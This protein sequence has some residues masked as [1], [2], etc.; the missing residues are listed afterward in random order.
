[1]EKKLILEEIKRISEIMN[2]NVKPILLEQGGEIV[3]FL[4]GGAKVGV[5]GMD[6]FLN[7]LSTKV[8][9]QGGIYV[10]K[11]FGD[12]LTKSVLS[13]SE[14]EFASNVIRNVFA[15]E[16]TLVVNEFFTNSS[17]PKKNRVKVFN[18]LKNGQNTIESRTQLLIDLGYTE[19]DKLTAQVFFD[20]LNKKVATIEVSEK[21]ASELINGLTEQATN[22]FNTII[23]DIQ[24]LKPK[25]LGTNIVID[26]AKINEAAQSIVDGSITKSDDYLSF[27]LELQKL[28]IDLDAKIKEI[29]NI[30]DKQNAQSFNKVSGYLTKFNR[31]CN[32]VVDFV[33]TNKVLMGIFKIMKTILYILVGIIITISL[34][35]L[36]FRW[37][38]GKT[39]E[40]LC[41]GIIGTVLKAGDYCKGTSEKPEKPEEPVKEPEEPVKE[42]EPPKPNN[43]DEGAL[44]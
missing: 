1:M 8:G 43:D 5:R 18:F 22:L 3:K 44:N 42:P 28:G 29:A 24:S 19:A 20:E 39:V 38:Y 31:I 23:N 6:D 7:K 40:F 4:E 16:I 35:V 41:S 13:Q 30:K 34:I 17:I 14:R 33:K 21:A 2:I 37:I 12:L 32:L 36:A 11:T 25:G 27:A 15:S 10:A 26:S 9:G